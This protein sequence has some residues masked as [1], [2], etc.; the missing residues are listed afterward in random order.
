LSLKLS[1]LLADKETAYEFLHEY[2]GLEIADNIRRLREDRGLTQARLAETL[3]TT[4]SVVARLEDKGYRRYSLTTL[5][6]IAEAF[7]RWPSIVFEPYQQVIH[8]AV[9]NTPV[10]QAGVATLSIAYFENLPWLPQ[11]GFQGTVVNA[12]VIRPNVDVAA[13]SQILNVGVFVTTA[14]EVNFDTGF[15]VEAK[16]PQGGE[17]FLPIPT[18]KA[19]TTADI[20]WQ[21]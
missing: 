17:L 8:R 12:S 2:T 19:R 1:D 13:F 9:V 21:H 15:I 20:A 3:G 7:D 10:T 11:R 18:P 16:E 4:Q 5:Q 14:A 6:K